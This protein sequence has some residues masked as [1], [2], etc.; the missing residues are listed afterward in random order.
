LGTG[1]R[2]FLSWIHL[3]GS[4]GRLPFPAIHFKPSARLYWALAAASSSPGSTYRGLAAAFRFLRS[5]LSL[6]QGFIG[7]WRP[8]LALCDPLT[9]VWRPP[10]ISC[11][12]FCAFRKALLG[13]GGRLLLS[14][15]HLPGSGGRLPLPAIHFKPSARLYWAPAAAF[16][17][18]R[19]T[20]R[21]LAAAF[22]FLRSILSLAQGFIG[23]RRPPFP[24][25]DPLPGV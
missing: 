13:T 14:A 5:I 12:P 21:G 22:R 4:G 19:S 10:F 20:Y 25:L 3:P 11:D 15:I 2:L 17:S 18:P 1:G 8:P 24:L 6:P 23:N 16:F 7:R 9:R